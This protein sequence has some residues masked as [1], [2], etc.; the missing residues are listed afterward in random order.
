MYIYTMC[1]L[2][3]LII[4]WLECLFKCLCV[5]LCRLQVRSVKVFNMV[6]N[7]MQHNTQQTQHQQEQ[8]GLL[9]AILCIL[10]SSNLEAAT[11]DL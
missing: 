3:N 6:Y 1:V 8:C 5:L 4:R 2:T 9:G 7:M 11:C 10:A